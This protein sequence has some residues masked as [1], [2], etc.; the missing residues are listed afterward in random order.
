MKKTIITASILSVLCISGCENAQT[1][2]PIKKVQKPEIK[3]EIKNE[4]PSLAELEGKPL[5]TKLNEKGEIYSD[6]NRI[7]L[8]DTPNDAALDKSLKN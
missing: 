3:T 8:N 1:K 7:M 2:M 4:L 6:P 5:P